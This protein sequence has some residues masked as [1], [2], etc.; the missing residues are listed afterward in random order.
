MMNLKKLRKTGMKKHNLNPLSWFRKTFPSLTAF[1]VA[2]AK[3]S[4]CVF[5]LVLPSVGQPKEAIQLFCE[6]Q[7]A[8]GGRHKLAAGDLLLLPRLAF[9]TSASS[10]GAT[11]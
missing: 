10:W 2:I 5:N 4:P 3:V 11:K 6:M 1:F 8:F 7:A 9:G